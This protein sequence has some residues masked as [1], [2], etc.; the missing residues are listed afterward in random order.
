MARRPGIVVVFFTIMLLGTGAAHADGHW[1]HGNGEVFLSDLDSPSDLAFGRDGY[2]YFTLLQDLQL[3]RASLETGELDDGFVTDLPD[4]DWESGTETGFLSIDMDTD[5][6]ENGILYASYTSKNDDNWTNVLSRITLLDEKGNAEE[7]V[8]QTRPGLEFHNGGRVMVADG[9]LWWTTGDATHWMEADPED[10]RVAQEDGNKI[11]KILRLTMDGKPAEDNPWGDHAYTKGHRNVF[12]IAW[13]PEN[14]RAFITENG[15]GDPDY[16]QILEAGANYGWPDCEGYCDE[17][18]DEFTDPV[19]Q[20]DIHV[21]PTGATWFRGAFWWGSFNQGD[22]YRTHDQNGEW[23][24]D[25][26]YHYPGTDRRPVIMGVATGPD[27][28]S[29]W[30]ST[31]EEIVRIPFA[32]HP[33]HPGTSALADGPY[34]WDL[35]AENGFQGEDPQ[36]GSRY[37]PVGVLPIFIVLAAV[38]VTWRRR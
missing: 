31:Y 14:E 1:D 27:E 25:N 24:V 2:V 13:D 34:W 20:A 18:Q 23:E 12:G 3:R 7:Q 16:I 22:L 8:L 21:A 28:N 10:A 29:L 19:W 5:F 17:P 9:H 35:A 38:L 11:G 26:V 32:E 33:D 37:S 4:A 36:G 6:H 30:I 15:D